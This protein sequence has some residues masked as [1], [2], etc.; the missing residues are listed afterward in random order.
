M[1][2][3]LNNKAVSTPLVLIILAVIVIA[4]LAAAFSMGTAPSSNVSDVTVYID[5]IEQTGNYTEPQTLTWANSQAGN[6]YTKNFTAMNNGATPYYLTLYTTEPAGTTHA[7]SFN[8]TQLAPATSAQGTLSFTLSNMPATGLY[9]WRLFASNSTLN[10]V[11]TPT[12]TP[13]TPPVLNLQFTLTSEVG[14]ENITVA[15]N[16]DKITLISTDLPVTYQFTSADTLTFK[17]NAAVGYTFN[18]WLLDS[19]TIKSANPLVL[20]DLTGNFTVQAKYLLTP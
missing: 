11:A 8:N 3:N 17:T 12:P 2:K 5:T 1:K 7:W 13:T 6:T 4:V 9:T 14:A 20:T 19:T 10:P 16:T 18:T 15:I